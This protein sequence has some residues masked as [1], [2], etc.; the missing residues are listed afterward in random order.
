MDCIG[1]WSY[2]ADV[3][4]PRSGDIVLGRVA[5]YATPGGAARRVSS[6]FGR[7]EGVPFDRTTVEHYE[8]GTWGI[9]PQ[10]HLLGGWSG[11]AVYRLPVDHS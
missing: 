10:H 1:T 9:A 2:I 5:Y 3:D 4:Q 8:P 6:E 7:E 11:E